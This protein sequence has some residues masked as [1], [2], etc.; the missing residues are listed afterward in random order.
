[1][2]DSTS[3]IVECDFTNQVVLSSTAIFLLNPTQILF[4]FFPL[5]ECSSAS[6]SAFWTTSSMGPTM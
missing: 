3:T 1:M 5:Y 4:F 6:F 2:P